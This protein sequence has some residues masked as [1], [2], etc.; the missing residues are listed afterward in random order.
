[1]GKEDREE[2][3]TVASALVGSVT[4]M[5]TTLAEHSS[6]IIGI[7]LFPQV[8]TLARDIIDLLLALLLLEQQDLRVDRTADRITQAA[9]MDN[10]AT[11]NNHDFDKHVTSL[12]HSVA[13]HL[14][15]WYPDHATVVVEVGKP[16]CYHQE[17]GGECGSSR[18][19]DGS[20]SG[21]SDGRGGVCHWDD[22]DDDDDD[23]EEPKR[24]HMADMDGG[25][26]PQQTRVDESRLSVA[27][28]GTFT[29]MKSAMSYNLKV[30]ASVAAAAAQEALTDRRSTHTNAPKQVVS[31]PSSEEEE[32]PR[33]KDSAS[34]IVE[35]LAAGE[36]T[37]IQSTQTYT[38]TMEGAETRD[39]RQ[40][41]HVTAETDHGSGRSG[42]SKLRPALAALLE[43][44]PPE[45]RQALLRAWTFGTVDTT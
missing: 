34:P 43:R 42:I 37:T 29:L 17:Q 22:W 11:V 41:M 19:D 40:K 7:S 9:V 45:C 25:S 39:G 16:N 5:L 14:L 8:C 3:T 20:D 21:S 33:D 27:L 6:G 18:R 36:A 12:L 30:A 2:V 28:H 10:E 24:T 26:S 13:E 44:L 1:M 23:T 32:R 38:T 31:K 35:T 4:R 15:R